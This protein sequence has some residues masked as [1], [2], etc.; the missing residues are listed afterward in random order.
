[1]R[2]A[3]A[4][5]TIRAAVVV[6]LLATT[7]PASIKAEELIADDSAASVSGNW[8]TTDTTP[9][10]LNTGYKYRVAGDGSSQVRW[11]FPASAPAGSY[12]VFA[13]WTSGPNRATNAPYT[14]AHA[15]GTATVPANQQ[16]NGGGWRSLGTF[17]FEPGRDHSVALSDK[18]DGVVVADGVRWLTA[19][20]PR[21]RRLQRQPRPLHQRRRQLSPPRQPSRRPGRGAGTGSRRA[22]IRGF[23]PRRVSASIV[24]RCGTSSSAAAG[25]ARSAIPVSRDFLFTRLH[26]PVVP[27]RGD[28]A[29]RRSGRRHAQPAR[30][31]TAA[32]HAHQRQLAARRRIRH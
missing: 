29:V 11:S 20:T 21:R 15:G 19:G 32:I 26:H 7:S 24:T 23:S 5:R 6:A 18:A 28:A 2:W 22:T 30:R 12:E 8:L 25:C 3:L 17:R 31:R 27:A 13:R 9:G 1:M 10:F 14:V 4:R 16:Q